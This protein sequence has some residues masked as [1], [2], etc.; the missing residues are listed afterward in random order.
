MLFFCIFT[1]VYKCC[2][3]HHWITKLKGSWNNYEASTLSSLQA[4]IIQ[5][6]QCN[7]GQMSAP[8][9]L[10]NALPPSSQLS[11][12]RKASLK[13]G[14]NWPLWFYPKWIKNPEL[15]T[16]SFKIYPKSCSIRQAFTT[17]IKGS[18]QDFI[19]QD[20]QLSKTHV[21]AFTA[22]TT[23]KPQFLVCIQPC[24]SL[25]SLPF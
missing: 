3:K 14:Y 21:V 10:G 13:L 12:P 20:R 6:H 7:H 2:N 4:E 8:E 1:S 5:S 11:F 22:T 16:A 18:L 23:Q 17:L 24:H 19:S 9:N 25:D 15:I